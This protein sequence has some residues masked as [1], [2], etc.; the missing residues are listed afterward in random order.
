M[1]SA[2]DFG[3]FRRSS[4][5]FER[6]TWHF[7]QP[8]PPIDL[9]ATFRYFYGPTMNAFDAARKD[10][11]EPELARELETLFESQNRATSGTDIGAT[12]L[13]VTVIKA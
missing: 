12:F 11:R 2:M 8:G 3:N 1:R 6:V 7:R 13:K 9:L 10:G 4:V 5:G